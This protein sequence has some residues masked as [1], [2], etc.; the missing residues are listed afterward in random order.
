MLRRQF[1]LVSLLLLLAGETALACPVC[2]A[3][4]GAGQ[5]KAY[6]V[7][8]VLLSALPLLL[9]GFLGARL[10]L[11]SR[12]NAGRRGAFAEGNLDG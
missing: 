1:A 10:Y 7:T 8:T 2:F 6:F 11:G 4:T 5:R 3:E 9:L 12:R